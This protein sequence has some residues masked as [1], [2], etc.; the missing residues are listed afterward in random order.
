MKTKLLL[1]KKVCITKLSDTRFTARIHKTAD[2]FCRMG[3]QTRVISLQ[4][5]VKQPETAQK[6]KAYDELFVARMKARNAISRICRRLLIVLMFFYYCIRERAEIYNPHDIFSGCIVYICSL[7]FKSKV[8]YDPDEL[9]PSN[10]AMVIPV[11]SNLVE[12]ML[13]IIERLLCKKADVVCAADEHRAEIMKRWY[14]ITD[15]T[16][17]RN[18]PYLYPKCRS[19]RL[20]ISL[21]L[22]DNYVL[23][24]YVGLISLWRGI[25]ESIQTLRHLDTNIGLAIIGM[26]A[27]RYIDTLKELAVKC[28]VSDRVFFLPPVPNED[29]V[30]LTSGADISLALIQ[31]KS[32][33]YYY[34]AP[35]KLYESL[36]AGIPVVASDFPEMRRVLANS[37]SGVLVDPANLNEIADAIKWILGGDRYAKLSQNAKSAAEREY[38]WEKEEQKLFEIV[39]KDIL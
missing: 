30:P 10:R 25:E 2:S 29:V 38:N 37:K 16:V 26:G 39:A 11:V 4:S 35:N 7:C 12:W 34:A 24:V 32:L 31:N 6:H 8:I 19:N 27:D 9:E 20:K 21:N 18:V 5:W 28:E 23:L 3:A 15:I 14:R 22:N 13:R 33:S 17:L 1:G 36:T